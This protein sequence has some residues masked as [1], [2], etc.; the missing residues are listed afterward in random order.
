MKAIGILLGML[1]IGW[2]ILLFWM[3]GE[4]VNNHYVDFIVLFG[5]IGY[6]GWRGWEKIKEKKKDE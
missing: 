5:I 2:H 3:V 4:S 6:V 1:H